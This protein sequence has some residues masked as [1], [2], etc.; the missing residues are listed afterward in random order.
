MMI[1]KMSIKS[2]S[3]NFTDKSRS[4]GKHREKDWEDRVP[5][6]RE[7]VQSEGAACVNHSSEAS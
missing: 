4:R 5:L 3:I 2:D 1:V 6:M 7:N